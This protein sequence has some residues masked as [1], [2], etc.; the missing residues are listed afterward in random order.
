MHLAKTVT[1]ALF[2]EVTQ[3]NDRLQKY[4]KELLSQ[5]L[6]HSLPLLTQTIGQN[7]L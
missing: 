5:M 7:L 1:E 3:N 4:I 2:H 6:K